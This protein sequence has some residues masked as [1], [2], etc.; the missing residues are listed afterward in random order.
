M[1][2]HHTHVYNRYILVYDIYECLYMW[3]CKKYTLICMYICIQVHLLVSA[4]KYPPKLRR[5]HSY[6][7]HRYKQYINI[8]ITSLFYTLLVYPYY[9][10]RH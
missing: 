3:A 1:S 5:H 10:N 6:K 4:V 2:I 7:T 9:I 8:L